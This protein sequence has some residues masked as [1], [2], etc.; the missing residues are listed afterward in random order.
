MTE[1]LKELVTVTCGMLGMG[2]LIVLSAAI[3][4]GLIHL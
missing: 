1:R 3:H 4:A 2:G